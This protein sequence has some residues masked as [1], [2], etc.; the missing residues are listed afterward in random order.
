[1]KGRPRLLLASALVAL[2]V[3]ASAQTVEERARAA[4][5]AAR[6]RSGDSDAIL[7]NYVTP[8]LSGE[9]VS[10]VDGSQS[11][12]PQLACQK[13]ATLIEILAQP[14]AS[15]DIGMLRIARD[16]D[17]DG[18]FDSVTTLPVPVSGI[19]ANGVISCEP[20]SWNKCDNFRWDVDG[21]GELTL[22]PVD[23]P[24][25]AGCYC[26]NNSCGA[27]LV[28]ANMASVLKDLGGGVVGTL[29]TADPRIGVAQA[30]VDGPVIRYTGAQ[31]TACASDPTVGQTAYRADPAAIQG[32]AFAASEA[33]SLFQALAASPAG[34]GK[35]EQIRACTIEREITLKEVKAADI[36]DR[37]SGGYATYSYAPGTVS[38][39]MGSPNDDSLQG[40]KCRLFD[41]FMTLDVK[42][43]DRLTSVRLSHYF[44]D[45]WIQIRV[46]GNL[47]LSDPS[48]WTGSGFPP[49]NCE[50][51][52]TWHGYPNFDLK[53]LLTKGQHVIQVRVAVGVGGEVYARI[54]AEVDIS[55]EHNEQIV[56]LCAGYAGDPQCRLDGE[57]VD[58]VETFRNGVGTGLKPL[59]Q[60]R[61]FGTESCTLQLTRDFFL[62]QRS[63]KCLTD[64]APLP[65][66]DLSRGAW[67]IDHSTET[68]LADRVKAQDGSYETS[69]RPFGLPD[70]GSV[71][72]CEPICKTRAPR[73]NADAAPD[74]VVG[75]RQNDPSGWDT[76]YHACSAD[77][78][79]PVGE[80]EQLVTGCGCLDDFPEAVVMMQTVRLSGADLVCTAEAR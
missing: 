1:M 67:I 37:I 63:Y 24:E 50:R 68:L 3:P 77:N 48:S 71:A 74:G 39:L 19:C 60:T 27:N 75:S 45:D 73:V 44:M 30:T 52:R 26:V 59:P 47:I 13:T 40:G 62:K 66:P 65:P 12:A 9:Q 18:S 53:P 34:F 7:Q 23:M 38:F 14:V 64:T 15:G 72:A 58:G 10:T 57:D 32:D 41:F 22:I 70:R 8:G 43:P 56:D 6:A 54:D 79:C 61:L 42:D 4:A 49:G 33:S 2:A 25:L 51:N 36:I 29:T 69:T 80:G 21:G 11:F 76:F 20:G 55:C 78:V 46:D 28:W 5:E 31:T 17:L 16:K 35:G